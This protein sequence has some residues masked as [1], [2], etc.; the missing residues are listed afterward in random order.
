M[1][2]SVHGHSTQYD[3]VGVRDALLDYT[4]AVGDSS[5]GVLRTTVVYA[6]VC[7]IGIWCSGNAEVSKT[8]DWGSIPRIPAMETE[9]YNYAAVLAATL[10][11]VG[12]VVGFVALALDKP[13]YFGMAGLLIGAALT[14]ATLSRNWA[15]S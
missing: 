13:M 14:W 5:G 9:E 4:S 15:D 6:I 10:T 8:L 3:T 2:L 12:V 11:F 1:I 7:S